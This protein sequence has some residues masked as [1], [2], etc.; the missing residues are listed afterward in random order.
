M[1]IWPKKLGTNWEHHDGE[2]G[3]TEVLM[4]GLS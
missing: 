3:R 2:E 4:E 1:L